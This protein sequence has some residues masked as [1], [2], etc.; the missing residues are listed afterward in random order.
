MRKDSENMCFDDISVGYSILPFRNITRLSYA[1]NRTPY[2]V[3]SH[4]T[5]FAVI[6]SIKSCL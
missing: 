3:Y 2:L 4:V 5:L 1:M 6:S